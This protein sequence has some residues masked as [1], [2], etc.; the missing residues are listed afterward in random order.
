MTTDPIV[1]TIHVS[2]DP[3]AAFNLFALRMDEWWPMDRHSVSA[4]S[5]KAAQNLT[6]EP[7]VG[8][9]LSEVAHD[10]AIHVWGHIQEWAPGEALAL[11]WHPGHGEDQQTKVRV[12]FASDGEG[13]RVELTHSGWE[14]LEDGAKRRGGYN[15]GWDGV[16]GEFTN[17]AG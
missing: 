6:L 12:T 15:S 13:T 10:G 16:L 8:G 9:A 2:L 5:G 11:T 7:Y 3:A 14:A 4:G 17:S 1:K